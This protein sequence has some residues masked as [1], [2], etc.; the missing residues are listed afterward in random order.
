MSK[1]SKLSPEEQEYNEALL[2][3]ESR[4]ESAV[5]EDDRD[6]E[7]DLNTLPP[8]PLPAVVQQ[9]V[10]GQMIP[11][12]HPL[13][14]LWTSLDM[15]RRANIGKLLRSLQYNDMSGKDMNGQTLAVTDVATFKKEI[16]D[17]QTGEV[18]QGRVVILFGADGRTVGTIGII[19][20]EAIL[21]FISFFGRPPWNPPLNI[22]FK[23]VRT[24]NRREMLLLDLGEE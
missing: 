3:S 4:G 20:W 24:A 9:H 5:H 11:G 1:K 6:I 21:G 10:N 2:A 18:S 12:A 13:Q 15:T 7:I 22:R 16:A 8:A 17:E 23:L 19:T 14:E